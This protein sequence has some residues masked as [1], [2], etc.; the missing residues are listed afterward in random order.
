MSMREQLLHESVEMIRFA[1]ARGGSVPTSVVNVVE[2]YQSH[3]AESPPLDPSALV[4]AHGRL[5]KLVA[6]ATP[7]GVVLMSGASHPGRWGF[8]GPVPLV[9]RLMKTAIG[10]VVVFI[11][12]SLT[13]LVDGT[14]I[15][16]V[17]S[18]GLQLLVNELFW[19]SA[20]GIGASFAMLF[21]VNDY[22]VR[23]SYD[24]KHEPSY[25]VKFFLGV[26]AGFILVTLVPL[27]EPA[28]EE[29]ARGMLLAKPT[30]AMLGGYSASA[31]YRILTRLV[32]AVE[33][34]FRGNAKDAIAEREQAAVARASEEASIARVRVA[35]KLV[36]LQQQIATG[37]S[38]EEVTAK[39]REIVSSLTPEAGESDAIAPPAA[40]PEPA[41]A[42][43]HASAVTVP[44]SPEAL[45][46]SVTGGAATASA[47]SAGSGEE[48]QRGAAV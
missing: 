10:C 6:P 9:R 7:M 43:P 14:D 39:I 3:P 1:F 44:I 41:A 30:I 45:V 42:A 23:C 46:T 29:A 15:D 27:P 5:A 20:A 36:A 22:I 47:P 37:G 33:S 12:L 16:I 26:M 18:N 2:Q 28:G 24:P 35:A 19:L 34:I 4:Q 40:H 11:L 17:H 13:Q 32:E 48:P 21:Q 8:L 38:G 25:W 31:V